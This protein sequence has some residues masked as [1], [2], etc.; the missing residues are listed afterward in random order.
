MTGRSPSGRAARASTESRVAPGLGQSASI[1]NASV[2]PLYGYAPG[3]YMGKCYD[4]Q[5]T[6]YD[7]DKR[8]W[9]C[10]GCAISFAKQQIEGLSE[11]AAAAE[12]PVDESARLECLKLAHDW[13]KMRFGQGFSGINLD[14][15]RQKAAEYCE[16]IA[17]GTPTRPRRDRGTGLGPKDGGPTAESGDAQ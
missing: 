12:L 17:S 9:R 16:F 1:P 4:C 10:L 15:I 3:N 2:W 7:L 11:C 13:A 8:A 6:F 14:D 5:E